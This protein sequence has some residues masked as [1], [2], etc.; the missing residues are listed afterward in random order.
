MALDPTA[1]ESNFRD[2]MKKYLVDSLVTT[3]GLNLTFDKQMGVPYI[4]DKT[5]DRW[6]IAN[7]GSLERK[8]MSRAIMEIVACTRRD[9]EGF[10]LAQLCDTILGYLT[11]STG[12]DATKR[13]TFYRSHA[14]EAWTVIGGIVV[15]EIYETEQMEAEDKTKFKIITVVLRFASKV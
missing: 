15:Q 5:V 2:S 8:D 6:V 3:E 4:H 9:N 13:I 12:G 10:R 1:R 14:T 11:V 7:F